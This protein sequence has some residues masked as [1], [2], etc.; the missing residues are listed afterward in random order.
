M[1]RILNDMKY[2]NYLINGNFIDYRFFQTSNQYFKF[3]SK[4][5]SI[6]IAIMGVATIVGLLPLSFA[7]DEYRN[8]KYRYLL[9][10]R[11]SANNCNIFS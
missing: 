6:Q 9:H 3:V 10:K 4:V 1:L 11:R 5:I 2:T 7:F 8:V